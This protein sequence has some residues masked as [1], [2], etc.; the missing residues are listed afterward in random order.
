MSMAKIKSEHMYPAGKVWVALDRTGTKVLACVSSFKAT[1]Q[2]RKDILDKLGAIGQVKIGE[3]IHENG[4]CFFVRTIT[5][6]AERA[7]ASN[8]FT[9]PLQAP[10]VPGRYYAAL[11]PDK[12][13]V[14]GLTK[15]KPTGRGRR[16]TLDEAAAKLG[17]DSTD[18]VVMGWVRQTGP[19]SYAFSWGWETDSE[20]ID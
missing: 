10:E 5:G 8:Q 15:L 16:I 2:Q 13:S 1:N 14:S 20:D 11:N 17:A 6:H 7:N 3:I 9:I 19:D 18:N 12:T 4:E